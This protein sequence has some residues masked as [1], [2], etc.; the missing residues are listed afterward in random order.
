MPQDL[1]RRA[2]MKIDKNYLPY[3]YFK[4]LKNFEPVE[5]LDGVTM[6]KLP[7]HTGLYFHSKMEAGTEL[8]EHYHN[9]REYSF[10]TKGKIIVGN[11]VKH[12]EGEEIIFEPFELHKIKVIEECEM[13]IQFIKDESFKKLN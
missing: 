11:G 10:I 2:L 9:A 12:I 5:I 3:E 1:I 8:I 7:S 6:T 13:Y 4:R